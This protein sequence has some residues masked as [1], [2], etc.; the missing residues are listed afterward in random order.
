MKTP[1][2]SMHTPTKWIQWLAVA[3]KSDMRSMLYSSS[4]L[5]T[6]IEG[7]GNA[8]Q[9]AVKSFAALDQIDVCQGVLRRSMRSLHDCAGRQSL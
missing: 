9:R 2:I 6:D 3:S 4:G 5:P 8:L 1:N 7:D